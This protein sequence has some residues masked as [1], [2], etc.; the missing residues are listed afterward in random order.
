MSLVVPDSADTAVDKA[1]G[2]LRYSDRAGHLSGTA[3]LSRSYKTASLLFLESSKI[4]RG[5]LTA[6]RQ[7]RRGRVQQTVATATLA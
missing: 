1:V 5:R 3:V 6:P 2:Q 4:P 7:R